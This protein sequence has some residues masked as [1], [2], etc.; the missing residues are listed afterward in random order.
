MTNIRLI[1]LTLH[2]YF[3]QKRVTGNKYS[4]NKYL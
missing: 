4:N 2:K 3:M 1:Y